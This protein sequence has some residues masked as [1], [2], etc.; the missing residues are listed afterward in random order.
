M[1]PLVVPKSQNHLT[2]HKG[3]LDA[4]LTSCARAAWQHQVG[5]RTCPLLVGTGEGRWTGVDLWSGPFMSSKGILAGPAHLELIF[6]CHSLR[7]DRT[8]Q[9]FLTLSIEPQ[10]KLVRG[11]IFSPIFQMRKPEPTG[12]KWPAKVLWSR[13]VKSELEPNTGD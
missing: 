10:N 4:L 8:P 2:P 12:I 6:G 5:D 7:A 11:G 9:T 13:V 1:C 3:C